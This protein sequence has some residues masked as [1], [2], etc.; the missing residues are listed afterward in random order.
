MG[1]LSKLFGKKE[2][3]ENGAGVD[4]H[5]LEEHLGSIKGHL[6][7]VRNFKE[8][9]I[10]RSPTYVYWKKVDIEE[11][12]PSSKKVLIESYHLLNKISEELHEHSVELG[13]PS[14]LKYTL[15]AFVSQI[16]R[17]V[18]H[19]DAAQDTEHYSQERLRAIDAEILT[20]QNAVNRMHRHVRVDFTYSKNKV[21]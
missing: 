5:L 13:S 10:S 8:K 2:E 11:A 7:E 21:G 14:G 15:D 16:D 4:I 9:K 18:H 1:M 12:W 17:I 19:I 20:V 6:L 3:V